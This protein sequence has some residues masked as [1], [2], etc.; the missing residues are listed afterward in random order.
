M[1][2]DQLPETLGVPPPT[3]HPLAAAYA[4]RPGVRHSSSYL[5]LS[6]IESA[7][8]HFRILYIDD[9]QASHQKELIFLLPAYTPLPDVPRLYLASKANKYILDNTIITSLEN[10]SLRNG[11]PVPF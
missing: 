4:Y 8:H 10:L 5:S 9:D 1:A 6:P 11:L 2:L 7:E 3:G